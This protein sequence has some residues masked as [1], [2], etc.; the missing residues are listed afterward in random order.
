[1]RQAARNSR[2]ELDPKQ[3]AEARLVDQIN[4][5]QRISREQKKDQLGEDFFKD[6][7]E[8]FTLLQKSSD[9]P[10]F[11]PQVNVPELQLLGIQEAI[12]VT[13]IQPLISLIKNL[14]TLE[15]DKKKEAALR[16]QWRDSGVNLAL[17]Y[18]E[19][20][21]WFTGTGFIQVGWDPTRRRNRGDVITP[22]RDPETVFPDPY[23][24]DDESWQY[25][26]LEDYMWIDRV[27]EIWPENASRIK[28]VRSVSASSE[29]TSAAQ[30][31]GLALGLEVPT[32]PM[33]MMV[34]G[35][36]A[37]SQPGDARVRVR[38][39][40]TKDPAR[41]KI[42]KD[43][44]D[45]P[46]DLE[47]IV[48]PTWKMKYPRGRM[49]VECEGVILY[50]GDNPYHHGE[51]PI[52]RFI[53]MPSLFG[54]WAP[55]PVRYTRSIQELAERMYTQIFE[56]FVRLNNGVWFIDEATGI[57]PERFGGIPGEVQMKNQGSPNPEL[58][59]PPSFGA[60]SAGLPDALMGLQR[61]L[62]NF[63]DARMGKAPAGNVS[64]PLFEGSI[65]QSHTMT[66]G[67]ARLMYRPIM[68]LAKLIFATMCQY[69]TTER[70]FVDPGAQGVGYIEWT[71]IGKEAALEYD[72]Y[73]DPDS[74]IP[75]SATMLR[76]MVPMLRNMGLID[77]ATA[78]DILQVPNRNEVYRRVQAEAAQAAQM[79]E[80]KQEQKK[81]RSKS[82]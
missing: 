70:R 29:Q 58:V 6:T 39:L 52:V 63:T 51:F 28:V 37:S 66:R 71:P 59:T 27:K 7:R 2:T 44:K 31:A 80:A 43:D 64:A 50:D 74:I 48:E 40:F 34:A 25:V 49:V 69:Y 13:D 53:M 4:T 77:V 72:A 56:N 26:I 30:R 41:V 76:N 62:Q 75:V 1:M 15:Q 79:A 21:G 16:A 24:L 36:P 46:L 47:G 67:R 3:Q 19:A 45:A 82:K 33:R 5:L 54:F 35:L 78:L 18:T 11:R 57:D 23:A 68:R 60:Q 65:S 10:I 14:D 20:I 17:M 38:T 73:L 8:F 61:R 9:A 81:S 55:P 22:W 12:D 42:G 32:G